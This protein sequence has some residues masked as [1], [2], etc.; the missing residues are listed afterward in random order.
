MLFRVVKD[1][2]EVVF[3][4]NSRKEA[5][6]VVEVLNWGARQE[7]GASSARVIVVRHDNG[8]PDRITGLT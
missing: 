6:A 3:E 7:P 1:D 2:G 5:E 8:G 4:T